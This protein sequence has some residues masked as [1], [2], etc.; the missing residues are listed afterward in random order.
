M[1]AT[2][3]RTFNKL[4]AG[5]AIATIAAPAVAKA[6]LPDG[7]IRLMCPWSAGGTIDAY[8]RGFAVIAERH[9]GRP[10]V[11]EN[12]P[13]ASGTVGLGWL[14]KQKNDGSIIAGIT[15][16]PFR[17]ALVQKVG[18]DPL[19]DF[20][21]LGATTAQ[22]FGWVV[23]KDSPYQD[24]A[25]LVAAAKEKPKTIRLAAGGTLR[26][27]A[28]FYQ[29]FEYV[30]KAQFQYIPYP[31]GGE[32]INALLSGEV[33][34]MQDGLGAVA[35]LVDSGDFR[36]IGIAG[37]SRFER[38][39]NVKTAKEQ[40]LDIDYELNVGLV[41]PAGI[42]NDVKS[43][44]DEA[45]RKIMNDP[46]HDQLLR[47]LNQGRQLLPGQSYA[48]HVRSIIEE[49]PALYKAMGYNPTP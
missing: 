29:L 31:G 37:G 41:A 42:P 11:V 8:C 16:A 15:D 44:F 48:S 39:P 32:M 45:L 4:L 28:F 5:G 20:D 46:A 13:G 14:A 25:Q 23:R 27:P 34:V 1:P 3:R 43:A 26:T 38:W 36:A 22:V 10:F 49:T 33:D 47:R 2:S 7:Y 30:A 12:R 18:F 9:L 35:G 19:K 40:G 24:L 6:A 21:Y 17:T